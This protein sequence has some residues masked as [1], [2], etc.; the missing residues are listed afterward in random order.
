MLFLV[1][2]DHVK[3]TAPTTPEGGR[4]F[5]EG[6][7]F[8]TLERAEE[9]AQKGTIVAGGAVVGRVALRF[10]VEAESPAHV[11]QIVTALPIWPVAETRVTPLI[12][13]GERR[14]HVEK[15]LANLASR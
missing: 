3:A 6:R 2:L 11:D 10:I 1:E 12:G 9:L 7:I 14:E 4:V 8:P 13:F 5:I 15:L